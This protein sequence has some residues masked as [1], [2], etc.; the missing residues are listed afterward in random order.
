V[1]AFSSKPCI[2][3][4]FVATP[5][6]PSLI[7]RGGVRLGL[8]WP[9]RRAS[10]DALRRGRYGFGEEVVVVKSVSVLA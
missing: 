7:R 3:R 1:P 6:R 2:A 9:F 10:E 8:I 4:S 5:G